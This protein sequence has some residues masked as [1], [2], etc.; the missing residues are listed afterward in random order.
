MRHHDFFSDFL[1]IVF[2]DIK[3]QIVLIEKE[4]L[5]QSGLSI[6]S[7]PYMIMLD[8]LVA[9]VLFVYFLSKLS[10]LIDVVLTFPLVE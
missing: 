2:K 7:Q 10:F 9:S 6:I 3:N 4:I 8:W 1:I 5:V